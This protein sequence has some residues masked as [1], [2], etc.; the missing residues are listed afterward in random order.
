MEF[1]PISPVCGVEVLGFD[2]RRPPTP[3]ECE[4]LRRAWRRHRLLLVRSQD[5]DVE[6]QLAFAGIFGVVRTP[7]RDIHLHLAGTDARYTYLSNVRPDGTGA[8]NSEL[9]PHQDY[10]FA[11]PVGG[12][13][14]H[15]LELPSLGGETGFFDCVA[16][17][18]RVPSELRARIDGLEARHFERFSRLDPPSRAT[19]PIVLTHPETGEPLLFVNEVFTEAVVGLPADESD[20]LLTQLYA[21]FAQPEIQYWH[22]WQLGDLLLFDNVVLQHARTSFDAGQAR[23]LRRTQIDFFS[24][25]ATARSRVV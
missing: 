15:A 23:T 22:R 9:L 8:G 12:I 11:D 20:A 3:D 1:R 14:L 7:S 4:T 17:L 18:A 2:A 6:Q 21:I 10:S 25:A 5:L 13:C 24:T 19:H 16:A